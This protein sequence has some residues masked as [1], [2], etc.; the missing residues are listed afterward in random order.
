MLE[1]V[2]SKPAMQYYAMPSHDV[3]V[4]S[5]ALLRAW[6]LLLRDMDSEARQDIECYI[7]KSLAIFESRIRLLHS[8][9]E[10]LTD[11]SEKELRFMLEALL[12]A[13]RMFDQV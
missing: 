7:D 1:P 6:P 4:F 13:K 10:P 12:A 5:D 9:A 3:L 2:M 8:R 11:V